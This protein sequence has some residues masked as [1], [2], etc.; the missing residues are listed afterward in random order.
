MI[1]RRLA[2]RER[3]WGSLTNR[4]LGFGYLS[5]PLS[6]SGYVEQV[7]GGLRSCPRHIRGWLPGREGRP[8]AEGPPPLPRRA[9]L[10][11]PFPADSARG[12]VPAGSG[13]PVPCPPPLPHS[14]PEKHGPPGAS[15]A[16]R[17]LDRGPRLLSIGRRVTCAAALTSGRQLR[18]AAEPGSLKSPARSRPFGPPPRS[19]A[20]SRLAP[21]LRA[22]LLRPSASL[23]LPS[24]PRT[25]SRSLSTQL[26]SSTGAGDPAAPKC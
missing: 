23:P 9:A 15:A 7:G 26:S 25:Y 11:V 19:A 5:A 14:A 6:G 20:G 12:G 10:G 17:A 18:A 24:G 2:D 8:A 3:Q 4:P 21:P 13:Q 16:T 22:P 1:Q